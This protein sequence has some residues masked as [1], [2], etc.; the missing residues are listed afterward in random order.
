MTFRGKGRWR[1]DDA[2]LRLPNLQDLGFPVLLHFWLVVNVLLVR[3]AGVA[4]ECSFFLHVPPEGSQRRGTWVPKSIR[5]TVLE[6][7]SPTL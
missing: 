6:A 1:C 5:I 3:F 7:C 4:L 2:G